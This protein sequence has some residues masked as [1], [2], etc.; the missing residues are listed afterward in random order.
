MIDENIILL[1]AVVESFNTVAK[2]Y[3][4]P[5][6]KIKEARELLAALVGIRMGEL[7]M[8]EIGLEIEKIMEKTK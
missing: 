3:K 1:T 6:N 4:I 2:T 8:I 5:D 7:K